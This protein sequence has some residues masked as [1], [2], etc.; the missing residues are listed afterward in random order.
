MTKEEFKP[1]PLNE[2]YFISNHGRV[3]SKRW[4]YILANRKDRKGYF[5]FGCMINGR[6]RDVYVHRAVC[7]TFFGEPKPGQ[8]DVNHKDCNIENNSVENLE[9]CT[10]SHNCK[11]AYDNG[12]NVAPRGIKSPK[13]KLTNEQAESIRAEYVPWKMSLR[14]LAR[15][16]GVHA[17]IIERIVKGWAY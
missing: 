17:R 12:L 9:W 13:S 6:K 1:F 16:Y 2:N 3:L 8:T 4:E 11:H 5:R 15:K 14:M 10:R 7:L